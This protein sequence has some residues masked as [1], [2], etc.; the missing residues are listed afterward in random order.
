[1]RDDRGRLEDILEAIS[2]IEKATARG[3]R[4]F[5]AS[6]MLQTYVVHNIQII[7]EAVRGLSGGLRK[8]HSGVPWKQIIE[9]R[10]VLVH[11]YFAVNVD[12]VWS[13]VRRDL[14]RLKV[15]IETILAGLKGN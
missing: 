8:T 1:M 13:V 14:P 9:M 6:E 15:R 12:R 5:R 7:G 2:R 10:N 11:E 3:K 4:P